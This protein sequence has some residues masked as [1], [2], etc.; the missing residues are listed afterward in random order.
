MARPSCEAATRSGKLALVLARLVFLGL[1]PTSPT[2][3]GESRVR[4][5]N[6]HW[7]HAKINWIRPSCEAVTWSG[8]LALL[9]VCLVFWA[10][11]PHPPPTSPHPSVPPAPA[12]PTHQ[13]G[14]SRVGLLDS[15]WKPAKIQLA[16]PSGE[17]ATWSGKLALLL[18]RLVFLGTPH[19]PPPPAASQG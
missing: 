4:L 8:K 18:A 7:K 1:P 3:S 2:P 10:L 11:L 16:L 6:F 5:L 17:A 19:P 15:H 13:G 14:E 9:L 12:S